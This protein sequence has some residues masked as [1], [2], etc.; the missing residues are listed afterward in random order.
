MSEKFHY[1]CFFT[2]SIA[3]GIPIRRHH[4]HIYVFHESF[5]FRKK[6]CCKQ[7]RGT[8][9]L[10]GTRLGNEIAHHKL[11]CMVNSWHFFVWTP[12]YISYAYL[13][14][15]YTYGLKF[16]FL[17]LQM[18]HLLDRYKIISHSAN[19]PEIY[20]GLSQIAKFISLSI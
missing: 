5:N 8:T 19:K 10:L 6:C 9:A 17:I 14:H 4:K 1:W 3:S 13:I 16:A 7:V 12:W 11:H 2:F 18:I 20:P 15:Q